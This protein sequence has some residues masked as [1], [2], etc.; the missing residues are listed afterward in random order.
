MLLSNENKLLLKK[1]TNGYE[2]QQKYYGLKAVDKIKKIFFDNKQQADKWAKQWTPQEQKNSVCVTYFIGTNRN[3][4][5]KFIIGEGARKSVLGQKNIKLTSKK[6]TLKKGV[7]K[8][9]PK[10][11]Q[12]NIKNY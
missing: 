11:V 8:K 10:K 12:N 9:T 3:L 1:L 4:S 6:Q 7:T 5:A 2:I